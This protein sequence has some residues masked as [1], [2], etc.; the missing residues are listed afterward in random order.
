M[1]AD[2]ITHRLTEGERTAT[3]TFLRGLGLEDAIRLPA[4]GL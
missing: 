3:W 4:A 2:R 1:I